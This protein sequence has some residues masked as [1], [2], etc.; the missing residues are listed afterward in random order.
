M[1]LVEVWHEIMLPSGCAIA[2]VVVL[3]DFEIIS[4]ISVLVGRTLSIL[5]EFFES[6]FKIGKLLVNEF[7]EIIAQKAEKFVLLVELQH[8]GF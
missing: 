4:G 6:L 3:D 8:I 2:G 7:F 5:I 1:I